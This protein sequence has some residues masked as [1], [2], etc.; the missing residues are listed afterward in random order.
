MP[1]SEQGHYLPE[2]TPPPP[3]KA[4]SCEDWSPYSDRV[5]FETAEFLYKQEQMSGANI[6]RLLDLWEASLLRYGGHAPFENAADV[7]ETIDRTRLSDVRWQNMKI[8]HLSERQEDNPPPWTIAKYDV[9]FRDPRLVAQE[10]IGNINF[11]GQIDFAPKQVFNAS[12]E[13]EL[14][15][16]MSGD[17]SWRQAVHIYHLR[18]I[19]ISD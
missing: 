11:D 14:R 7:Y 13:R 4:P 8:G 12:G 10:M 1:C 3:R 9:W 16:F 5:G 19:M 6:D 18:L 17:F 15:D 2:K